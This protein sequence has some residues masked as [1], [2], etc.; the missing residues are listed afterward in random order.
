[1]LE[2][3]NPINPLQEIA[4]S[5]IVIVYIFVASKPVLTQQMYARVP[6]ESVV[7]YAEWTIELVFVRTIKP[8]SDWKKQGGLQGL[9]DGSF[10]DVPFSL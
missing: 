4:F 2:P 7:E 1:M 6:V 5:L 3:S 10:E 8:S 9:S